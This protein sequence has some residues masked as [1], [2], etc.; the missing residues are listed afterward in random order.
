MDDDKA[1]RKEAQR[2]LKRIKDT[3]STLQH[4]SADRGEIKDTEEFQ[5]MKDLLDHGYA[6][7]KPC[8][9]QQLVILLRHPVS[10][11]TGI[12][13]ILLMLM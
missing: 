12:I 2:T 5:R 4:S 13:L 10:F 7:N 6:H 8:L 11:V 9:I 3:L 1:L